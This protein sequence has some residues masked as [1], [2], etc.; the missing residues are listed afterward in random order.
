MKKTL[1]NM[2]KTL[3]KTREYEENFKENWNMSLWNIETTL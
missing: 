2:K 1:W 3:K